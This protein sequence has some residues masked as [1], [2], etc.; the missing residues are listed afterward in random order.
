MTDLSPAAQAV[1][2]AAT[3]ALNNLDACGFNHQRYD[4]KALAAALRALDSQL[5]HEILGVRGVDCS[6]IQLIATELEAQP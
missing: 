6:Q 3:P 1:M 4:R 2:D 5:G